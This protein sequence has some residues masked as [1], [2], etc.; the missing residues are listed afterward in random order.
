MTIDTN[1]EKVGDL[2]IA[3]ACS[4]NGKK[5]GVKMP[6]EGPARDMLHI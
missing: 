6:A 2:S 1:S 4:H 3:G 5:E